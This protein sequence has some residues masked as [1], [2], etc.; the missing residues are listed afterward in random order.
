MLAIFTKLHGNARELRGFK[1]TLLSKRIT[2]ALNQHGR[3][4]GVW[5]ELR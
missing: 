4:R 2:R 5:Y 1:P 3:G